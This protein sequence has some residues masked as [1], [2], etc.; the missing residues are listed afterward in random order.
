LQPYPLVA[1][2]ALLEI[3]MAVMSAVLLLNELLSET[4]AS[5]VPK[6]YYQSAY[7]C[8]ILYILVRIHI[9]KCFMTAVYDF[10]AK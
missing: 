5:C 9:A 8:L 1:V 2:H 3:G 7:C 10:D 4:H 6:F